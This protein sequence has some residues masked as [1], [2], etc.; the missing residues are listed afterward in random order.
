M[1]KQKYLFQVRKKLEEKETKRH[2]LIEILLI[3]TGFIFAG[4]S[5]IL[6]DNVTDLN[7]TVLGAAM[8]VFMFSSVSM[9]ICPL[10]IKKISSSTN[11][12]ISSSFTLIFTLFFAQVGIVRGSILFLIVWF[13]LTSLLTALLLLSLDDTFESKV[14]KVLDKCNSITDRTFLYYILVPS[15]IPLIGV[16]LSRINEQSVC[17]LIAFFII[18]SLI[19][20]LEIMNKLKS[21]NEEEY[22][23]KIIIEICS[24]NAFALLCL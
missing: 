3:L 4:I 12:L 15:L 22:V 24:I 17:M 5:S 20:F 13:P 19:A 1:I 10:I 18:I 23:A 8:L 16:L 11:F 2:R 6:T 7:E 21:K 9:Y 14:T